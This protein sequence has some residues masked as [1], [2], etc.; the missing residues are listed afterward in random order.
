MGTTTSPQ[1]K[2]MLK[3]QP[4]KV[5]LNHTW[6]WHFTT[7]N[8]QCSRPQKR[9]SHFT[10]SRTRMDQRQNLRRCR[11]FCVSGLNFS[12][13]EV[14]WICSPIN[15]PVCVSV[16]LD[17]HSAVWREAFQLRGAYHWSVAVVHILGLWFSTVGAGKMRQERRLLP[18][19]MW[20][21]T[22]NFPV[23]TIMV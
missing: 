22:S 20:D 3:V 9:A 4:L 8:F 17:R 7:C 13:H 6:L 21:F 23:V 15:F 5:L 11:M 19:Q 12:Y 1:W 10:T 18:A 2:L 14:R 16:P